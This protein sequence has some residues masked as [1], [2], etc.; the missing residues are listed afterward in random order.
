MGTEGR[1]TRVDLLE[2][3]LARAEGALV[4]LVPD[5]LPA[6]PSFPA[7]ERRRSAKD[8]AGGGPATSSC[9]QLAAP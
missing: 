1:R 7:H 3:S 8:S 4:R 6:P 2:V 9:R 5:A